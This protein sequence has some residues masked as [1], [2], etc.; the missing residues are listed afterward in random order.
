MSNTKTPRSFDYYYPVE[1]PEA[2]GLKNGENHIH[3]ATDYNE[4]GSNYFSG[5][6]TPRGYSVS[7]S[8]VK[9]E[10]G[11]TSFVIGGSGFGRRFTVAPAT[12]FN[13][14]MLAAVDLAVVHQHAEITRL[15]LAA[16]YAGIREL[17]TTTACAGIGQPK[18]KAAKL[19]TLAAVIAESNAKNGTDADSVPQGSDIPAR[20]ALTQTAASEL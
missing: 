4:G 12:R 11:I 14:K 1:F 9:K 13:A 3:I 2:L 8:A 15:A 18:A 6:T 19:T 16:D 5:G 17:L 7:V 10:N 20:Q